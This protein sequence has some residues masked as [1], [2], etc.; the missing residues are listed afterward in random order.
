MFKFE[1]SAGGIVFKKENNETYILVTQHSQHHG[2]G[3]PK[4]LIDA[5]E[6]KQKAALREVKE[7]GGI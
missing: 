2:W 1:E 3:F 5:G 7:E 4:G 6:D